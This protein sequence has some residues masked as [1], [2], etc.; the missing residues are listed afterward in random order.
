MSTSVLAIRV[1]MAQLALMEQTVL[2]A[3][4]Y[5]DT[6]GHSVKVQSIYVLNAFQKLRQFYKN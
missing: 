5:P 4:A 3:Y 1:E 2:T 6:L